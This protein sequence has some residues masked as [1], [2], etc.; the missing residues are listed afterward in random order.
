VKKQVY[1]LKMGPGHTP[2]TCRIWSVPGQAAIDH[3]P[4][5]SAERRGAAAEVEMAEGVHD[6]FFHCLQYG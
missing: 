6:F 3:R 5:I 4:E 2:S 1:R